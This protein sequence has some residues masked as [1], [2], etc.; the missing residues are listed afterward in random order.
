MCLALGVRRPPMSR[1]PRSHGSHTLGGHT[2]AACGGERPC[3]SHTQCVG[4]GLTWG[5][6]LTFPSPTVSEWGCVGGAHEAGCT[7]LLCGPA[8]RLSYGGGS[9]HCGGGAVGAVGPCLDLLGPF[10]AVLCCASPRCLSRRVSGHQA[11]V[12]QGQDDHTWLELHGSTHSLCSKVRVC[13]ACD[14]A[15]A[16]TRCEH[17]RW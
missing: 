10:M 15:R 8:V 5:R 13:H 14:L 4:K 1:R 16:A 3:G 11:L 2:R 17:R 6:P 12:A 7:Q 9:A